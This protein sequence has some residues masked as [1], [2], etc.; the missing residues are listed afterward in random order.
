MVRITTGQPT[1]PNATATAGD[2]Q[3]IFTAGELNTSWR[4]AI[5]KARVTHDTQLPFHSLDLA[6]PFGMFGERRLWGISTPRYLLTFAPSGAMGFI[7]IFQHQ[8][9]RICLGRFFP[10]IEQVNPRRLFRVV[11]FSM[12]FL[13]DF[14]EKWWIQ[15]KTIVANLCSKRWGKKSLTRRQ[16]C[17]FV[18][19]TFSETKPQM[20]PTDLNIGFQ[21]LALIQGQIYNPGRWL[22]LSFKSLSKVVNVSGRCRKRSLR[23]GNPK[24][25]PVA[26]KRIDRRHPQ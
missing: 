6:K 1:P 12:C 24:Q 23:D 9:G 3:N 16:S 19:Y 18:P 26:M 5:A 7:A 22:K 10:S 21:A 13:T 4:V 25:N 20:V 15:F 11:W 8:F 14:F 2:E 17:R